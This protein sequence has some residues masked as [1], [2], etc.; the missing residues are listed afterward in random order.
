MHKS[1]ILRMQWFID[2]YAS[3]IAKNEVSVLDV[4]SYDVNGSY[5]HLFDEQKYHYTGLDMEEGPNV[6]VVLSN[7]YDWDAIETDYFD[8]VI[9]GQA[10]EHIEFFW[11]TMEEMT[12]VL[13][14]EGL[15]CLIVPNGFKEHR[16]PVDCYRFYTDG[17]LALAKYVSIEPLHAHTNCAP[18]Q[19]A[20]D[21]YSKTCADSML[22]AR[23]PYGGKT[24]HPEFK[25][26]KCVP[27]NQEAFR[28]GLLPFHRKKGVSGWLGS[29]IAKRSFKGKA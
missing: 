1:S 3:K 12:R 23:K 27:E 10:F 18:N 22:I 9:S 24:K 29:K 17:M 13:K 15:L 21:W 4:G 7:S 11:K 16:Y 28:A 2:N 25:T 5:K 8:I 14:E 6:D 19:N 26:Y 20:T